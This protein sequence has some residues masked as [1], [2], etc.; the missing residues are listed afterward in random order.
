[1]AMSIQCIAE[2]AVDNVMLAVPPVGVRADIVAVELLQVRG[3]E[4]GRP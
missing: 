4:V 3:S 2:A 1:M